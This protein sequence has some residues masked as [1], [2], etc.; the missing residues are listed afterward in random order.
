MSFLRIVR[1]DPPP[2]RRMTFRGWKICPSSAVHNNAP[3]SASVAPE[4]MDAIQRTLR[5]DELSLHR[6]VGSSACAED[7]V[8]GV[9]DMP[10]IR[11]AQQCPPHLRSWHPWTLYNARCVQMS[12]HCI[13]RLDPPPAPRMT[14]RGWKICPSSAVHNNAP[15]ICVRGTRAHGRYTTHAACR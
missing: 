8:Q 15:L 10:V 2:A 7:D 5:A 9:E 13:V 3:S 1:L 14:F 11:C 6:E 4:H 12:F